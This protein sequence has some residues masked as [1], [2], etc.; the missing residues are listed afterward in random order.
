MSGPL[1]IKALNK[2]CCEQCGT[3]GGTAGDSFRKNLPSH[4]LRGWNL[5]TSLEEGR[6]KAVRSGCKFPGACSAI[7]ATAGLW[8]LCLTFS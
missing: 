1:G 4:L 2:A 5:A 3:R 7:L 6:V 8:S